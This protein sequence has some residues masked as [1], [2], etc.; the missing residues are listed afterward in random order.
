MREAR[1]L[2]DELITSRGETYSSIS[3]ILG[4][5]LAYIQQYIKRGTPRVLSALDEE[6]LAQHFQMPP[7]FLRNLETARTVDPK[8]ET[9]AQLRNA[10]QMCRGLGFDLAAH[11]I[12][13]GLDMI[14]QA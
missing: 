7:D 8:A 1:A 6:R 5:N 12:Q 4:R 9:I 11:Q 13:L 2:L 3:L 14:E 10:I